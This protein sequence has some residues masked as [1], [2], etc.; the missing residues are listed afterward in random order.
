MAD[1]LVVERITERFGFAMMWHIIALDD[2]ISDGAY[3][4][5]AVLLKYARQD[6]V[7][8]PGETRLGEDL[9][10]DERTVRRRF[11]ELQTARLVSRYRRYSTSS[12][13][14]IN[15][16]ER[17]YRDHPLMVEYKEKLLAQL[18]P[19]HVGLLDSEDKSDLTDASRAASDRTN[20]SCVVA[21]EDKSVLSSQD[22]NDR[23]R[24]NS[25]RTSSTESTN[26]TTGDGIEKF[27]DQLSNDLRSAHSGNADWVRATRDVSLAAGVLTLSVDVRRAEWVR[28]RLLPLILREAQLMCQH[29]EDVDVQEVRVVTA[30]I[31]PT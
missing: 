28:A 31:T 3:R 25:T 24:R 7:A 16:V 6:G 2:R 21:G 20:L 1:E 26:K 14:V 15:D 12:I 27:W 11:I 10:V 19:T 9:G 30:E 4:L 8:Y 23:L 18:H 13:T 29:Y 5:Y 17:V 22:T